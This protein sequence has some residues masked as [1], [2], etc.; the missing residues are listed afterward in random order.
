MRH[1]EGGVA[2]QNET[3]VAPAGEF[4]R[5]NI[6]IYYSCPDRVDSLSSLLG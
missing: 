1:C 5:A 4:F 6:G 2:K 3:I